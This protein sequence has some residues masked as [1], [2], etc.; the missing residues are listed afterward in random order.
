LTRALERIE[1]V[2]IYPRLFVIQ[3]LCGRSHGVGFRARGLN[4]QTPAL[5]QTSPSPS[6]RGKAYPRRPG[7]PATVVRLGASH[8]TSLSSHPVLS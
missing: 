7:F 8:R 3:W 5:L 1:C 6:R 2:I 4:N